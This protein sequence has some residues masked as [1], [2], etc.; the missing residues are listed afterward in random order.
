VGHRRGWR[1]PL[2]DR[3][4]RIMPP[5]AGPIGPLPLATAHAVPHP[6]PPGHNADRCLIPTAP[7]RPQADCIRTPK[8]P[9]RYSRFPAAPLPGALLLD[10]SPT[11]LIPDDY[12]QDTDAYDAL[13]CPNNL[14]EV[15]EL[16]VS[17]PGG[18]CW[19]ASSG[20]VV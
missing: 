18:W 11:C 12:A 5:R 10:D 15:A 2:R 1:D 16:Q 9:P 7:P 8:S 19:K 17:G 13:L 14:G 3:Y 6:P 20:W 4:S